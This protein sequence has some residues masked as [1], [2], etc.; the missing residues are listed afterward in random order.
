MILFPFSILVW[1]FT[2]ELPWLH[3]PLKLPVAKWEPPISIALLAAD[4]T[5]TDVYPSRYLQANASRLCL[6]VP[7][8]YSAGLSHTERVRRSQTVSTCIIC[9]CVPKHK[10]ISLCPSFLIYMHW[11]VR[12]SY[13][14]F[15]YFLCHYCRY[16]THF[17]LWPLN[18]YSD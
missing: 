9:R 18:I 12:W 13:T 14:C 16:Y 10:H 8:T 15:S 1:G 3:S 4:V 17:I 6:S 2:V 11:F 7:W 5:P